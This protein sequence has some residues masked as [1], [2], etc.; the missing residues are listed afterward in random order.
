MSTWKPQNS[1]RIS[2]SSDSERM[3]V[4]II[5]VFKNKYTKKTKPNNL[6]FYFSHCFLRVHEDIRRYENS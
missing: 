6:I 4:V 3:C 1:R 5:V 2:K